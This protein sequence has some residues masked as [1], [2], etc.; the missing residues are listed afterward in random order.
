M[1]RFLDGSGLMRGVGGSWKKGLPDWMKHQMVYYAKSIQDE[2]GFFYYAN[3]AK[4]T[5]DEMISRRARDIG[6]CTGLIKELGELPMYDAPNGTPGGGSSPDEYW[7]SL[8]TELD[9]PEGAKALYEKKLRDMAA[10]PA[11]ALEAAAERA[12]ASTAYL[13]SHTA[14]VDYLD[15]RLIPG[16]K[17]NPYFFGNEVGETYQQVRTMT[18]KLGAYEYKETDGE[19]Y[20]VFDG[21]SLSDILIHELDEAINP[22]TALWGDLRPEKP[23]GN[24]FLYT[25]GFM[26]GMAAYNGLGYPYPEKYLLR[27]ANTLMDGL[28]GDEPSEYNI[29]NVYNVW[30]A[31]CRLVENLQ[32]VK[33]EKAKKEV[34]AAL[35]SVLIAKAPE[36]ILNSYKKQS[37]YKK[38]DGGFGHSYYTGT[39]DH[40]G[41]PISTRENAGDVDATCICSNG[42]VRVMFEALGLTR[43]PILMHSD[44]MRYIN[45]LENLR[46][47]TKIKFLN[48]LIDFEN[49]NS[50][51]AFPAG[52]AKFSLEPFGNSY[53]AKVSFGGAGGGF[54]VSYTAHSWDGDMYLFD[55]RIAFA[56]DADGK[57]FK[58]YYFNAK[59]Y[60]P[61]ELDI[62]VR[63]GKVLLGSELY[64]MPDFKAVGEVGEAFTLRL[65]YTSSYEPLAGNLDIFVDDEY[66]GRLV[67]ENS[68]DPKRPSGY[69]ANAMRAFELRLLSDGN[70]TAYFDDVQYYY[71]KRS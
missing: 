17:Q 28:L 7:A 22:E 62:R 37:G 38:P 14:F 33:C 57:D 64:G 1:L 59:Q 4:E 40:Q 8:G 70:C 60:A 51:T 13:K 61:I 46:P 71:A 69:P 27:V 3:W 68:N 55:G 19:R 34:R 29:C 31:V 26:K 56:P 54:R 36:A 45:I 35:R 24:E 32:Y 58:A 16:M 48:P 67:N 2:N 66:I 11:A 42:M 15:T 20:K 63:E 41:L 53:A 21:M 50:H 18:A 9:P 49:G 23:I 25:N 43:V 47:V 52:G 12:A 65:E 44:Y 30:V 6:W 39:P 5:A 10:T